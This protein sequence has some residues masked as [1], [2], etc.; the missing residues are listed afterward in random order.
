MDPRENEQSLEPLAAPPALCPLASAMEDALRQ[1]APRMLEVDRDRLMFLAG[2]ASRDGE[3]GPARQAATWF[4][5]AST[6]SVSAL[7]ACLAIALG[8]QL[9]RDPVER[10][11]DLD[12]PVPQI[13]EQPTLPG[14]DR[15]AA[16][17]VVVAAVEKPSPTTWWP[18][19]PSNNVLQMRNV[20][21]RWGVDAIPSPVASAIGSGEP[22]PTSDDLWHELREPPTSAA[23]PSL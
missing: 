23:Q 16:P 6:I 10:I 7:A 19:L 9:T 20:A 5:P 17:A 18:A 22:Q 15:P 13:A 12:P 14:P 2:Q 4:W 11:V 8:L 3:H 1:F 21:L